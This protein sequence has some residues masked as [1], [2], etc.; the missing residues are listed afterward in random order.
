MIHR[1]QRIHVRREDGVEH[2]SLAYPERRNAI[3][4]LMIYEILDALAR[5]EADP[6]VRV[7]VLT[8]EGKVFSAGGD[9]MQWNPS[10]PEPRTSERDVGIV[11]PSP[12]VESHVP[13]R[14]D[15]NDLL[16]AL[17]RSTRPIIARVNGHALGAGLGLVLASTFAVSLP[18]A[19]FGTPEIHIGL[20]PMMILPLLQRAIAP[21]RLAEMILFGEKLDAKEALALGILS[22]IALP[23]ELDSAVDEIVTKI[24]S[25]SA[26]TVRLGMAALAAQRDLPLEQGLR[27]MHEQFAGLLRT[28]DAR[29]GLLSFLEKRQPVWT[30]R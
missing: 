6:T 2:I 21:R 7:V 29:E 5:V 16:S 4:P 22:D 28:D 30:G 23:G 9:F 17:L 25:K 10:I 12:P 13:A 15:Y 1:Y 14:G 27:E 18:D 11:A 26:Q 19:Q 24:S 8:G 3:G 20:F